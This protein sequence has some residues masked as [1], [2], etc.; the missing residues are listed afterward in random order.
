MASVFGLPIL[1]AVVL[2]MLFPYTAISMIPFSIVFLVILMI[3][4]GLVIEW[5]ET[6]RVFPR[7][8][9]VVL[10]LFL[11]FVF[12]PLVLWILADLLISDQQYLYGF[13]F[14]S[15]CPVALVSPYFTRL[16]NADEQMSFLLMVSSMIL[17]PLVAPVFL[18][19]LFSSS[20]SLNL[21]P[22]TRYM[23]LLVTVPLLVSIL[24]AR[25]LPKVRR[26]ILRYDHIVN[27]LSLSLL[28]FTLF[29]TARGRVNIYYVDATQIIALLGLVFLQDFGVLIVARPRGAPD[30][31]RRKESHAANASTD[32]R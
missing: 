13:V 31:T 26:S 24:I 27:M 4:A 12:F 16:H 6:F 19:A 32:D 3:N 7:W 21:I 2:G 29:G 8:Q 17:C 15:L 11:L 1:A 20:V 28:V 10:G 23:L 14:S 22:L 30:P 18:A 9:E 25:F 5:H